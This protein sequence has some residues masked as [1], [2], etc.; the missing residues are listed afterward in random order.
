MVQTLLNKA[1]RL[2]AENKRVIITLNNG[3]KIAGN[4]YFAGKNIFFNFEQITLNRTPYRISEIID[5]QEYETF[6]S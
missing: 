3:V 2:Q 4:I 6:N 1:K 5:I